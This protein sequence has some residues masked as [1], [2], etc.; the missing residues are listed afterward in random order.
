MT[1]HSLADKFTVSPHGPI[2]EVAGETTQ[3]LSKD[4]LGNL[5][6][7]Q[8]IPVDPPLTQDSKEALRT[9]IKALILND[10]IINEMTYS[11]YQGQTVAVD[12][13]GMATRANRLIRGKIIY[14]NGFLY[15]ITSL[16]ISDS[17][18]NVRGFEIF[19]QFFRLVSFQKSNTNTEFCSQKL[20][21]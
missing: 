18:D 15:H 13:N 20:R 1:Y 11:E 9:A 12:F 4:A 2:T 7:V 21:P 19:P 6:C 3:Y 17:P 5:Y 16:L 8:R 10:V 14:D